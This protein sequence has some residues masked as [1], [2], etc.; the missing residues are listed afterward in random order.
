MQKEQEKMCLAS[1]V[2][3]RWR[4]VEN[5]IRSQLTGQAVETEN[6]CGA[7]NGGGRK[8]IC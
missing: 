2:D 5:V 3:V 8:Q 4:K 7:L 6:I 1:E